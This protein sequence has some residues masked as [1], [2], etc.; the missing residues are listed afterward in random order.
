V[1]RAGVLLLAA[2]GVGC[3]LGGVWHLLLPIPCLPLATSA[4]L[5]VGEG[6]E[7]G[8]RA[9]LLAIS[10][11]LVPPFKRRGVEGRA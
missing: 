3:T 1:E 10:P 9:L 8:G 2:P 4:H 6:G 7:G 5:G 11:S